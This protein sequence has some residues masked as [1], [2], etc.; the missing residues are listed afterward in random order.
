MAKTQEEVGF[1]RHLSQYGRTVGAL[2]P[3]IIPEYDR[4]G[5]QPTWSYQIGPPSQAVAGS[6]QRKMLYVTP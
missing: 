6:K 2:R 5:A 1:P 4:D 3:A